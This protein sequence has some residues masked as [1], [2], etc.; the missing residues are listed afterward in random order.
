MKLTINRKTAIGVLA[1]G[2]AVMLVLEYFPI[3]FAADAALNDIIR[4][5]LTR[6]VGSLTFTVL[7]LYMGFRVHRMAGLGRQ[8]LFALPCFAVV[9]NNLPIIALATGTAQVTAPA[10]HIVWFIFECIFIGIFEETVFRGIIYLMLLEKRRGTTGQIFW[11]T[12][13]SSAI[14]GGIHLINLLAGAGIG[15]TLLQVGYSFLIGGMCSV[16]LL[17]TRN[18]WLC[19]LLHAIYDVCGL[20]LPTLGEGSWWDTPTIIITAVLAVAVAI[21]VVV[22]LF[23][24]TPAGIAPIFEDDTQKHSENAEI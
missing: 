19:A 15:P 16:V 7:L 1:A 2:A 4:M 14:F 3:S 23:R 11:T 8:L 12:V 9:I 22:A 18:I 6:G 24:V 20:L 13:W 10:G 21:Y 17:R 5:T